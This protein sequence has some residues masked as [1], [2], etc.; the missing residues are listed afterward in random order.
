MKYTIFLVGGETLSHTGT[1]SVDEKIF[2]FCDREG[3]AKMI[4][5]IE[6][7]KYITAA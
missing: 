3:N 5:P 4:V 7:I 2:Y 6:K 1:Y